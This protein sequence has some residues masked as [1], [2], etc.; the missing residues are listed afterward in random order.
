MKQTILIL[1]DHPVYSEGLQNIL[2]QVIGIT[3]KAIFTN[4]QELLRYMKTETIH[5]V[6]LDIQLNNESGFDV[7]K[8][9]KIIYPLC[10]VIFISMFDDP[11]IIANSKN[12]GGNGYIHKSI[13]AKKMVDTIIEIINGKKIYLNNAL[14]VAPKKIVVDSEKLHLLTKRE[15]EIIS[16]VREGKT[17]RDIADELYLSEFTIQTHRKNIGKKLNIRTKNGI[18]DFAYKHN[19]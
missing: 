5:L 9:I 1:D 2:S 18:I 6:I 3:V 14:P 13:D 8:K 7:C 10:K 4:S 12:A 11:Q 15:I 19:L 17:S 16:L